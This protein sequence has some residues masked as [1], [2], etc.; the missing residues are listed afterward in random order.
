VPLL[1]ASDRTIGH[2]TGTLAVAFSSRSQVV[3]RTPAPRHAC[4]GTGRP[5]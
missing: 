3:V 1:T 4:P 5:L 2:V